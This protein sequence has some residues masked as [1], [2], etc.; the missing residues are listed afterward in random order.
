MAGCSNCMKKSILEPLNVDELRKALKSDS[1]FTDFYKD[2]QEL[3][4]WINKSDIRQAKYGEVTYKRIKKYD[5]KINDTAYV[6]DLYSTISGEYYLLYP[7]YSKQVD[8][9]MQYWQNYRNQNTLDSLVLIEFDDLYKEYYSYS[10]DIRDVNIGFKITPLKGAI[11]Q[12]IFKYDMQSKIASTGVLGYGAHRCLCS[13][14]IYS[15]TTKYWECDYSDRDVLG[16]KSV[17]AVKRDYAFLI[18]IIEVRM[19]GE[20][21]SERLSMIPQSVSWALK[22]SYPEIYEDDIIKELLDKNYVSFYDFSKP[23]YEEEYKKI[24]PLVFELINTW[25][26]DEVDED[27]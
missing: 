2:V 8:S 23:K 7:D 24:D 10:G 20:N 9:I 21:M 25:L 19:N 17:S 13:S 16:S 27:D 6:K 15:S 14:P 3:R 1:T 26:S 18:E 4:E 11:E 22:S 12:L 5:N